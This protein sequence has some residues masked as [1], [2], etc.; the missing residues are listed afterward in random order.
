MSLHTKLPPPPPGL[1]GWPWTVDSDPLPETLPAETPWPKISII[2]P[3]YNQ[4]LYLEN[5]I[6]SVLLQRYPNLEYII[7]DGGSSDN[8]VDIIKKYEPWLT[9]WVS[10]KDGGQSDAINKGF[11]RASGAI[12][13]WL[14]SDDYFLP[15]ALQA[16]A[17][18]KMEN[19]QAGVYVGGNEFADEKGRVTSIHHPA[20]TLD[21]ESL[22]NWLDLFHFVQ[23]S[24]FF[25]KE[26]WDKCGPLDTDFHFAMDLELWLRFADEFSFARTENILSASRIHPSAKT[27]KHA[28][29]SVVES[30]IV[31]TRHGGERQALRHLQD[32]AAK[33]AWNEYYLN[34][35]LSLPLL[36]SLRKVARRV[37]KS[38]Q[39]WQEMRGYLQD[40]R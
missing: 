14:N 9:W 19:P 5:T 25:C 31:F 15:G 4:G 16:I 12:L 32:L 8:S 20:A 27:T 21:K 23:P 1:P 39:K 29:M 10:E 17:A 6:R 18:V 28:Y 37:L 33:A 34:K 13:G 11:A 22:L 38:D 3:S 24:C 30:C 7:V 26:A 36:S 2:T 40:S 35:L